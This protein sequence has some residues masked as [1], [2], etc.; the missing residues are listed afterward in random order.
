MQCQRD[1]QI[2]SRYLADLLDERERLDYESHLDECA[3][4]RE[5]PGR[6]G[7]PVA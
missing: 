3:E 4:C 6:S 1:K 7:H 2:A 5:L